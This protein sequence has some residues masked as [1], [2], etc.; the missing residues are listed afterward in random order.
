LTYV[1]HY[2]KIV[3]ACH[4]CFQCIIFEQRT[5]P[6]GCGGEHWLGAGWGDRRAR[7]HV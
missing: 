3:S 1:K 6:G 7:A 2:V 5:W 4:F